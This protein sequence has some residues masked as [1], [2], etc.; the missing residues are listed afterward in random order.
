M[1]VDTEPATQSTA[2]EPP[3]ALWSAEAGASLGIAP[4]R[5]LPPRCVPQRRAHPLA[6]HPIGAALRVVVRRGRRVPGHCTPSE[7]PSALWSAEAG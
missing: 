5:S 2:P 6:L 4:H 1:Y 7:P 3:S